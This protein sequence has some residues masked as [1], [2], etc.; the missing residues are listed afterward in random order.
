MVMD[1]FS[2]KIRLVIEKLLIKEFNYT[3]DSVNYE[4]IVINQESEFK[5]KIGVCSLQWEKST[6]SHSKISIYLD[7][8]K[9]NLDFKTYEMIDSFKILPYTSPLSKGI[10]D[11]INEIG[12]CEIY[13]TNDWIFGVAF[14]NVY[15]LKSRI[16][17][18]LKE[19]VINTIIL[20]SNEKIN[21]PILN[22]DK[23]FNIVFFTKKGLKALEENEINQDPDE[24]EINSLFKRKML[25]KIPFD[26][27][28]EVTTNS[29]FSS[30]NTYY[31]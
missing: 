10:I 26:K 11:R 1:S 9:E 14:N 24:H 5:Y 25:S 12:A 30:D 16:F 15:F 4:F 21:I 29:I 13:R 27:I 22:I 8:F 2:N 7:F 20:K 28:F 17:P 6:Y 19:N 18:H 3:L 31:K 23:E